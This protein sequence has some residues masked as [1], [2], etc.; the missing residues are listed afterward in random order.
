MEIPVESQANRY[1]RFGR[2]G[3]CGLRKLKFVYI[4]IIHG[5]MKVEG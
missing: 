2:V 4:I 3:F 1:F 5:L